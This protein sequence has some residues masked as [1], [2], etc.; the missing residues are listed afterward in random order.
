MKIIDLTKQIESGMSVYLGDPEVEIK[1]VQ[2]IEKN[3]WEL[4]ELKLGTH[5]GTHVDAISHMHKNGKT[6]DEIPITSFF[7]KAQIADKEKDFPKGSGLF[8]ADEVGM[9]VLERLLAAKPPFVG[10]HIDTALERALLK[11]EIVTYTD[12]IHLDLIPKG[13]TFTFI[14]LPL[15]IK[16][17]DGSPVRA[18]ALL[19]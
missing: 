19:E 10:G 13:V 12:L 18:I 2:T 14:G 17:G 6:L 4:R 7:G 8:F 1:V 16:N 11:E 5:T 9:E 3:T 15:K